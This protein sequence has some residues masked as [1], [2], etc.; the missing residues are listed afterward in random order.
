MNIRQHIQ[1]K[2]DVAYEEFQRVSLFLEGLPEDLSV[3]EVD[4][5]F[6]IGT[7]WLCIRDSTH[8]ELLSYPVYSYRHYF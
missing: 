3:L 5:L 1:N 4:S 8:K 2:V 7:G 6:T